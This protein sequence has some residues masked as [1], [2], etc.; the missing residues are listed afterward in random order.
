[1]RFCSYKPFI[2][3]HGTDFLSFWNI[4][5]DYILNHLTLNFQT[6]H[7]VFNQKKNPIPPMFQSL[8]GRY[9]MKHTLVFLGQTVAQNGIGVNTHGQCFHANIM[10][11]LSEYE[12]QLKEAIRNFPIRSCY[13][14]QGA[15]IFLFA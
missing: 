8:T 13:M 2:R 1:M 9:G 7:S 3:H 12:N 14:L 6:L 5:F 4:K 11:L 15:P 10:S